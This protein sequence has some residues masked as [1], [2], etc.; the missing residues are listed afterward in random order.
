M[1]AGLLIG[2]AAHAQDARTVTLRFRKA[3]DTTVVIRNAEGSN[4]LTMDRYDSIRAVQQGAQPQKSMILPDT[5]APVLPD[6]PCHLN[7]HW[8]PLDQP[9][10]PCWT[11]ASSS[12]TASTR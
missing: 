5:G 11:A 8:L 2:G 9:R 7:G 1:G 12:G 3:G 4:Q 10:C 6:T